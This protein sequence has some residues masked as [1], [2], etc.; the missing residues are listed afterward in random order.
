MECQD[1]M[2]LIACEDLSRTVGKEVA[3][4]DVQFTPQVYGYMPKTSTGGAFG[5]TIVSRQQH[6]HHV[7]VDIPFKANL[8]LFHEG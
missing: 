4:M 1:L 7:K 8:G 5:S 3:K 2:K 6:P